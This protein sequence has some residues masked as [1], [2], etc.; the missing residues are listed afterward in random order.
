MVAEIGAD[1]LQYRHRANKIRVRDVGGHLLQEGLPL[2]QHCAYKRL[3]AAGQMNAGQAGV[4]GVIFAHNESRILERMQLAGDGPRIDPNLGSDFLLAHARLQVNQKEQAPARRADA[5]Q[6]FE[7]L[8]R[9]VVGLAQA[10]KD[11]ALGIVCCRSS[12]LGGGRA[13]FTQA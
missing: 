5:R 1:A 11:R 10:K 6:V 3:S 12:C 2:L 8:G 7:S 13:R 9:S 4:A